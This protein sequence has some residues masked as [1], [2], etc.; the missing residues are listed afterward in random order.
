MNRRY[1]V[2]GTID[3][4]RKDILL[5]GLWN[6]WNNKRINNIIG[7]T[8]FL[9]SFMNWGTIV[10]EWCCFDR[11]SCPHLHHLRCTIFQAVFTDALLSC[12][13]PCSLPLL[14]WPGLLLTPSCLYAKSDRDDREFHTHS[15]KIVFIVFSI[16]FFCT[17][18]ELGQSKLCEEY[19]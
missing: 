17:L 13:I 8:Y 4:F 15:P 10:I 14:K 5:L 12:S 7:G 6:R 18:I 3:L 11:C 9:K 19:Q 1:W 16:G 2:T